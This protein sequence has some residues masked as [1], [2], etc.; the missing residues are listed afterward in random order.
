MKTFVTT[1]ISQVDPKL[2]AAGLR[3]SGKKLTSGAISSEVISNLE[4]L[5]FKVS[6]STV[7]IKGELPQLNLKAKPASQGV[8]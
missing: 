6:A 3:L 7:E 5:G 1:I 4:S 8:K 2:V